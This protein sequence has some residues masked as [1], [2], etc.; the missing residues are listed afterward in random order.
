[1]IN[2]NKDEIK[3]IRKALDIE[4]HIEPK[5]VK[6]FYD[7]KQ[8]HIRIPA[9]LART[10]D[11]NLKKDRIKLDVHIDKNINKKPK[12]MAELVRG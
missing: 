5:K 8:Y 11:L 9:K 2:I 12:L 10:L 1:M 6:I 7:G 3:K 4:P